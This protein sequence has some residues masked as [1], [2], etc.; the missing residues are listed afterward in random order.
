MSRTTPAP[1]QLHI[2]GATRQQKLYDGAIELLHIAEPPEGYYLATSFGKDSIV[3]HRLCDEAGVKYDAHHNI[4][5]I[6][7]P[8]LVYF[9]RKY[10]P[11][12][13]RHAYTMSMWRLIE[14]KKALP[15]RTQRFCC[16]VLKEDGGIGR[17][18]VM[19]I[20]AEES[21]RRA[22]TWE[23]LAT[24]GY[25]A[26]ELRIFDNDDVQASMQRC[27]TRG[28]LVVNPLFYWTW[29]DLWDFI[30]DRKMPYCSLYNEGF[31]RLGCI[32]CPMA[33]ENGRKMEFSR[34]PKFRGAYSRATQRVINA[35]GFSK[36]TALGMSAEEIVERW[37][38]DNAQEKSV[39][40]QLEMEL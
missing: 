24:R 16:T 23:P 28:K 40:G 26:N 31:D 18:C 32:G 27:N 25:V 21:N 10:Y 35:G 3:A 37:I 38:S 17:T 14:K 2:S 30:C 8:E 20:R 15:M 11:N 5:G 33:G 4:T 12:V 36:L 34:W 9:G 29:A 39:Y 19:G 1:G 7:P 13:D 22:N 6:D